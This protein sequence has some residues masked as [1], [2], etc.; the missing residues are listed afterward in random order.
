MCMV[1]TEYDQNALQYLLQRHCIKKSLFRARVVQAIP[2]LTVDLFLQ[3]ASKTQQSK[4]VSV[5][6]CVT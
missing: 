1:C 4:A 5:T 6:S 2:H 3:L